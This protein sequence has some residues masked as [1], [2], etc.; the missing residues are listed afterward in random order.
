MT[1][2]VLLRPLLSEP[3][4]YRTV[5][6]CNRDSGLEESCCIDIGPSRIQSP[7]ANF[8]YEQSTVSRMTDAYIYSLKPVLEVLIG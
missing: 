5:E 8:I 6:F 3:L 7:D 4:T 1:R 2:V